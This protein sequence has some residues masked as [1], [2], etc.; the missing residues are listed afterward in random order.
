M[1]V[2]VF[3][4]FSSGELQEPSEDKLEHSGTRSLLVPS[5]FFIHILNDIFI[6]VGKNSD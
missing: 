1:C 5:L 4:Q 2:F 6:G 3:I